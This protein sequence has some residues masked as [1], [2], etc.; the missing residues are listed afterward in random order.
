MA[1]IATMIMSSQNIYW[2]R[3]V[4][5]V[6]ADTMAKISGSMLAAAFHVLFRAVFKFNL[7]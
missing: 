1:I 4:A 7:E 5:F 3:L 6:V 2:P